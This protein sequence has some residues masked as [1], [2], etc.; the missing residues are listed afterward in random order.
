MPRHVVLF[1]RLMYASLAIGMLILALDGPRKA[2]LPE[3]RAAGGLPFLIAGAVFI[4]AIIALIVWLIARRRKNWA[5]WLLAVLCVAGIVAAVP[6][7]LDVLNGNPAAAVLSGVQLILQL[8]ALYY[9][10][11]G[12]APPWFQKE[13]NGT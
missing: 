7:F 8:T 9:I 2:E 13:T 4:L 11:T 6:V 5:R 10:F 12:D 1:E 3:I